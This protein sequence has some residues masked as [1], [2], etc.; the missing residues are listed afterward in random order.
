MEIQE[1]APMENKKNW[2]RGK[3]TYTGSPI[4]IYILQKSQGKKNHKRERSRKE[5]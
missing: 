1:E 5:D 3:E 4:L 2:K